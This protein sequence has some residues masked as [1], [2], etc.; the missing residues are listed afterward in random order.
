MSYFNE[1]QLDHMRDL[2]QMAKEGKVCP[3][4][5]FTKE[6]CA[7]RCNSVYRSP[8]AEIEARAKRATKGAHP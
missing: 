4:G 8:E 3:C 6:D 1:E 2:A 5:W 7:R